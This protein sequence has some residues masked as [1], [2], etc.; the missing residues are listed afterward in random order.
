[1]IVQFAKWGNSLALRVPHALVLEIGA[2]EGRS[3]DI[4]VRNGQLVVTPVDE[5]P[6]YDLAA[7][8]AGIT[9]ENVHGE[10]GT[11]HS[12]GNELA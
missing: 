8:L 7:L 5:M 2:A 9:E 6:S 10:V 11:G 1:M 12:V 3:A 4:S